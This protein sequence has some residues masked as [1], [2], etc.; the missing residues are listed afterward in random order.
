MD[1]FK[2]GFFFFFFNSKYLK[3][4]TIGRLVKSEDVEPQIWGNR[5]FGGWTINYGLP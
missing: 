1:L 4:Y 5:I 3:C 2:Q